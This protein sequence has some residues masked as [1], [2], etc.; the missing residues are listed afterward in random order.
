MRGKLSQSSK[1]ALS[2]LVLLLCLIALVA[3][4]PIIFPD[5][6]LSAPNTKSSLERDKELTARTYE[7]Y[8]QWTYAERQRAFTWHARSTKMIFWLSMLVS[9]SGVGFSFWQFVASAKD[10]EKA[11]QENQMEIKSAFISLAFKSR[12]IAALVLFM[13]MAYLIVYATLIYPINEPATVL[14]SN[15]SEREEPASPPTVRLR[16]EVLDQADNKTPGEQ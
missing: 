11:A 9:V 3:L 12:S 5:S 8:I 6:G 13:S 15:A 1:V 2:L 14:S 4:D 10:T 7:S 16:Q